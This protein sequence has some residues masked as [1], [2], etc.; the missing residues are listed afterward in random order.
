M[1]NRLESGADGIVRMKEVHM[2]DRIAAI[3]DLLDISPEV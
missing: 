3:P 2:A 1:L